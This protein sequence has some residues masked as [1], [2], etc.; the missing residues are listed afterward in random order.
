M[1]IGNSRNLQKVQQPSAPEYSFLIDDDGSEI[2][3]HEYSRLALE[4]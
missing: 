1:P 3:A 4:V 2:V